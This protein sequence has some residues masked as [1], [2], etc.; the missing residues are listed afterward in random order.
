MSFLKA[1]TEEPTTATRSSRATLAALSASLVG[2]LLVIAF[3]LGRESARSGEP[4]AAPA[5]SGVVAAAPPPANPAS[6]V[7]VREL[8]LAPNGASRELPSA[9]PRATAPTAPSASASATPSGSARAS[10]AAVIAYLDR[11]KET[12]SVGPDGDPRAFAAEVTNAAL[13]GDVSKF[14][15]LIAAIDQALGRVRALQPP[16]EA[17]AY[18]A[19][20]LQQLETSRSL[21]TD[22][23]NGMAR[24]D[25]QA[26]QAASQNASRLQGS[27]DVLAKLEAELRASAR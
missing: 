6:S 9:L 15:G 25:I 5:V 18:H 1:M 22:I 27:L 3:L 11:V 4:S 8:A 12:T 14:D 21:T 19:M 7:S 13:T 20:L 16:A 23:R 17:N 2:A 10:G 24:K 26:L